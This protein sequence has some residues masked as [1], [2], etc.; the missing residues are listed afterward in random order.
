MKH[1]D[2]LQDINIVGATLVARCGGILHHSIP[3]LLKWCDWVLLMIDNEDETTMKIV[4]EYKDRYPDRIRIAHSGLPRATPEQ[5]SSRRGLFHRFKPLQ[6][7]I[8]ETVFQYMRDVEKGGEK[9]DMLIW[10]DSDEIF[11]DHLPELLEKFWADKT[12]KALTMKPV[13]VFGDMMTIHNKSMTGHTRIFKFF[14]ELTAIPYRTACNYHPLTK[15]DRMGDTRTLTHLCSLTI[16]KRNWRND[17]WKGNS[18]NSEALW[19][20]PKPV[21]EMHPQEVRDTFRREPDMTVEDYLRG[22]DKRVPV[23]RE[24]AKKALRETS[25]LLDK[26]G[27]KHFLAFGTCLGI[28]RD[29]DIL[30]YDWDN[31]FIIDARDTHKIDVNVFAKAGFTDIKI[32]KDIPRVK[33]KDGYESPETYVRTLSF[34]KYGV[35]NDLDPIYY[36][37][38][39]ATMNILKGRKR[40]KFCAKHPKEWFENAKMIKYDGKGYLIPNPVD[41]YLESNYGKTWSE[42][43]YGPMAWSRRACTSQY[44]ACKI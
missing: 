23:G 43:I 19:R 7:P 37:E 18:R 11:N 40:Q 41:E 1:R 16:E 25:D 36:D 30:K 32:K 28:V 42:P 21:T 29:G 6:G 20:L 12:K 13:D 10:P 35:R 22:G 8:R 17:H 9:V 5:E 44:Y 39:D 27:V 38:D 26:M 31:D 2:F 34:K 4:Q 24:N 15:Q 14:T 3:N 33:K